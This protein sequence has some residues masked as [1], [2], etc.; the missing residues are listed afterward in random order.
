MAIAVLDI[1]TSSMRGI[2]YDGEGRKQFTSQVDYSPIYKSHDWVEQDPRDWKKA[3]EITM[4]ACADFAEGHKETVEAVSVTSQRSSVIPIGGDDKPISNAI[5]WQDKRVLEMAARMK[6]EN[7]KVFQ[8]SGSKINPVF[9]GIKMKW[10]RECDPDLYQKTKRLVVIPDYVIR[11][12]TGRWTTDATYASRSSLMNL[13]T[14]QWDPE[15]LDLFHVDR[16]ML[17][18]IAEPGSVGGY[19]TKECGAVTGLPEGIPV[20]S[21]GGDQQCGALGMGMIRQGNAEISAGTGAYLLAAV[22]HV[23]DKMEDNIICNASAI[24]GNYVMESSIVSCASVFN[25]MLRLFYGLEEGNKKQVYEAVNREMEA[26]LSKPS[27]L[28]VLPL[29]QGRGTPDW[30]SGA[31]GCIQNLTLSTGRGEIARG[32]LEGLAYEIAV[33]LDI[34]QNYTG[35]VDTVSACGGIL[36]SPIFRKILPN[37]LDKRVR[38]YSDNEATALGAFISAA[39]TLGKYNSYQ[40]AFD[41][42]RA[43]QEILV[44]VPGGD[45]GIWE[46]IDYKKGKADYKSLYS[47][48]YHDSTG[49]AGGESYGRH[50]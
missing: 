24:P 29:F 31:R 5:M 48:L 36:N 49:K 2:L 46:S 39:V 20:I 12:M 21:A 22:E 15:L 9:S 44:E 37:V 23:P 8:L 16:E 27:S 43:E 14:R 19:V 50:I 35:T 40:E 47:R 6:G 30:N 42:A 32:V 26:A 3:M 38:T 1:G 28:Q 4:R 33:N 11:E 13:R 25:W 10:I 45:D 34:I 41:R 18:E 7:R 17:C